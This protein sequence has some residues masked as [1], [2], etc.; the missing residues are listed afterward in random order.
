MLGRHI[1]TY[2]EWVIQTM[3]EVDLD[4]MAA[5]SSLSGGDRDLPRAVKAQFALSGL[6]LLVGSNRGCAPR[7]LPP[8]SLPSPFSLSLSLAASSSPPRSSLAPAAAPPASP[9]TASPC[10]AG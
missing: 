7:R 3:S 8:P 9:P 6:Q 5:P 2:T 4:T 10:C 1:S